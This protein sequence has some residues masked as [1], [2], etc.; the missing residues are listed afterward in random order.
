MDSTLAPAATGPAPEESVYLRLRQDVLSGRLPANERL[1]VSTLAKRY[2]TSTNPVREA[3]QQL[4]G[5]GL[6]V[7][8]PNRGARVREIDEDFVRDIY[9][10]ETLVEPFMIRWFV[11]VCT[12]EDIAALDG[13]QAEI[14]RLNFTD[15]ERHSDLDTRFHNVMYGHHYNRH[16]YD[17]WWSHREFLRVI[18]VGYPISLRR[19]REVIDEHRGLI[20]AL[21]DHDEDAAARIISQHVTGSGRH[22]IDRLRARKPG[23]AGASP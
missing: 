1:K 20:Q 17:L 16:A 22:I 4:R 15:M 19:Q 13:I 5:E 2:Q 7:I 6:V 11:G 14:E 3:L 10:I 23:F 12:D 9:E 18:N 21:R 8:S